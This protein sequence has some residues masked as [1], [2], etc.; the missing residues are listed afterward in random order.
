MI[1]YQFYPFIFL[2]MFKNAIFI[3]SAVFFLSC[4]IITGEWANAD[5]ITESHFFEKHSVESKNLFDAD[6]SEL[7]L[8]DNR[9]YTSV[10]KKRERLNKLD[11]NRDY[12]KG[13]FSIDTV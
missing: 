10:P 6:F 11:L 9:I 1:G 2:T 4:F 12:F 3:K 5:E 8:S 7:K 13:I